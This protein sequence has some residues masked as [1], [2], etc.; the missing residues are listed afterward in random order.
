MIPGDDI[1]NSVAGSHE[2]YDASLFQ[3][4]LSNLSFYESCSCNIY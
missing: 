1:M 3:L 4:G 2:T